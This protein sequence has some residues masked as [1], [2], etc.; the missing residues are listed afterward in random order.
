MSTDDCPL[1]SI[2]VSVTPVQKCDAN[3]VMNFATRSW[4]A[5]GTHDSAG[6]GIGDHIRCEQPFQCG[7][8]ALL[9]RGDKRF[10][11]PPLFGCSAIWRRARVTNWHKTANSSRLVLLPGRVARGI[12]RHR[13]HGPTY[14]SRRDRAD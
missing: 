13:S 9:C 6:I 8:I 10:E 1:V 12:H 7:K 11:K 2:H 5:I 4:P 14:V 3:A